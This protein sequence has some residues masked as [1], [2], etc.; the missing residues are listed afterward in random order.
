M[1]GKHILP[2]RSGGKGILGGKHILL[3]FWAGNR[4]WWCREGGGKGGGSTVYR[5][6]L[7]EANVFLTFCPQI[8]RCA[9][10][11]AFYDYCWSHKYRR[12]YDIC[13]NAPG[14]PY[15]PQRPPDGKTYLFLKLSFYLT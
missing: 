12:G 10:V 1:A 3:G 5:L 6:G 4:S 7:G 13:T 15:D 14:P 9:L 2:G 11:H 8:P